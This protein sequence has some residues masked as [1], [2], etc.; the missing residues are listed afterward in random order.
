MPAP[1]PTRTHRPDSDSIEVRLPWW[2]VAL[3]ALAFAALLLLISGPGQAH[4]ATG[5]PALG[6]LL[7][8]VLKLLAV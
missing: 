3:P 5:A 6:R 8:Q 4:A 7:G 1:A 2:A